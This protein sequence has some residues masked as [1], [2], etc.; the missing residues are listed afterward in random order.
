M[1]CWSI[2]GP[3]RWLAVADQPGPAAGN[4]AGRL[5]RRPWDMMP[6]PRSEFDTAVRGIGIVSPYS[7]EAGHPAPR[8]R[9]KHKRLA[10]FDAKDFEI[11]KGL[12]ARSAGVIF[13]PN[14]LT[15]TSNL[16]RFVNDPIRS[17]TSVVLGKIISKSEEVYVESSR[18]INRDEYVRLGVTDAALLTLAVTGGTLLTVD[19]DLFLAAGKSGLSAIN[20]NHLRAA[21]PDFQ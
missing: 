14:V 12:I 16:L 4:P 19:L 18:A 13:T 6:I 17:Q 10:Q 8:R 21:R 11:L 9:G 3:R 7:Q 20:Y 15:E 5:S 1:T 2:Q